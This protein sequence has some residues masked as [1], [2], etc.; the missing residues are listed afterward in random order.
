[1]TEFN[2]GVKYDTGKLR[3]DLLPLD[4]IEGIV[5]TLTASIASG[6]YVENSWQNVENAKARYFAAA[7][8]H[9][10]AYQK[11]E[12]IDPDSGLP[13]LYHIQTNFMFLTWLEEHS[14]DNT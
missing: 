8:R 7:M 12:Y 6:K 10:V 1:M 3:W 2:P 14:N 5:R 9:I 11:G 13:H 4:S